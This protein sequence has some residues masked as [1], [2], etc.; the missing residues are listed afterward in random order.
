MLFG[1]PVAA[2]ADNWLHDAVV[3]MVRSIHQHI[4]ND[5][6]VP[7]WPAIIPDPYRQRLRRRTG[8]RDR[9][10]AYR[11]AVEQLD[12]ADRQRVLQCLGDQN[13]I[14][15]L[16]R[17]DIECQR[18]ADLPEDL[19]EP[20]TRLFDFAFDLLTPL[21]IRDGLYKAI[22]DH[23]PRHVCPFCGCEFFDA[24]TSRREDL[25]HYLPRSR[26]PFAAANLRNLV[27]MGAKCNSRYKLA[28]DIRCDENGNQRSAF[29]PYNHNEVRIGLLN[30]VPFASEDGFTPQWEIAFEPDS[31]E[32][33]TWDAVFR[34]RERYIRD[35][36]NPYFKPWLDQF[37]KYCQEQKL[38]QPSDEV[39][40]EAIEEFISTLDIMNNMGPNFL[41]APVF[42]MIKRNIDEGNDRL[43]DLMRDLASD[44]WALA[45]FEAAQ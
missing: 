24:P 22:Y 25:D 37:E 5:E 28:Q 41:Q 9:V 43:R 34:I 23:C 3:E 38:G 21:G 30:S 17:H 42:R 33:S 6:E 13:R 40:D 11:E 44:G 18:L 45:E 2:T 31:D 4:A 35:V 15:D 14:A 26:Y 39:L 29:D 10:N 7:I 12:E 36:L 20:I 32:C 16:L 27:P 19:R 1:Y 8:L